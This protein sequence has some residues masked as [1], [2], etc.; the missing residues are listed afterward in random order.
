MTFRIVYSIA[1]L[2]ISIA[3]LVISLHTYR[4]I[5]K[6]RDRLKRKIR[7]D[8]RWESIESS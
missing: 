4:R 5:R 6:E 2:C 8:E 3:S 7:G 1:S